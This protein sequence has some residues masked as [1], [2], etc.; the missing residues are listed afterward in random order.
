MPVL[1]D[2]D[3][4][5]VARRGVFPDQ[6]QFRIV[7]GKGE[8]F[9]AV[10]KD[11]IAHRESCAP[12]SIRILATRN[13]VAPQHHKQNRAVSITHRGVFRFVLSLKRGKIRG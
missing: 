5:N 8:V 13:A 6:R 10:H 12:V 1:G 3:G 9:S 2:G 4:G 7:P 11:D